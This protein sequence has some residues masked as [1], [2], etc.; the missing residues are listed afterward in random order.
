MKSTIEVEVRAYG[1]LCRFMPGKEELLF[2]SLEDGATVESLLAGLE[3]PD[4]EVWIVSLNGTKAPLS[5]RLCDG[6]RV[7][8]FPPLGGGTIPDLRSLPG[9]GEAGPGP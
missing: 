6:D 5:S 4:R 7:G 1:H 9:R 3:I 8:I 2:R